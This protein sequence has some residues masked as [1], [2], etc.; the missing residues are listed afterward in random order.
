M[1][2]V[3]T[4]AGSDPS[5]GAGIQ[6]DLKTLA[7]HGV[8]GASVISAATAQNT[9]GVTEIVMLGADFVT[10]QI[11][12]VVADI[13]VHAVKTGMLGTAAVV[14]AVAA[15]VGHLGLPQVVV[16]PVIFA[17]SGDRLLDADGVRMLIAELLPRAMVVTP[18]V[19]EAEA[20]SG[21]AI[22]SPEEAREAARRIR[23][24]GC[25]AVIITGGHA[26]G[27]EVVDLVYDGRSFVECRTPRIA[28]AAARG[29]GCTL[30]SAVAAHLALGRP[31]GEAAS[32]AQQYV[33]G[34]IAHGLQIGKGRPV[35]D[36]F[37][38]L[39]PSGRHADP[40]EPE[41]R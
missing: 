13:A 21:G 19:P 3:L 40:L 25:S 34:A 7:A 28:G 33:A 14:E 30:A 31:L 9:A 4:I 8:Y 18:N 6:A 22:R 1:R 41:P 24:M 35:L 36:H 12:V 15:A 17:T 27:S 29:T 32:L 39:N 38:R 11:E 23:A 2:T 10:E 26:D 20:L 37:W 16:D 5:G